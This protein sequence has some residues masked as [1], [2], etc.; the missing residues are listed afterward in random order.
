MSCLFAPVFLLSAQ[1]PTNQTETQNEENSKNLW[2]KLISNLLVNALLGLDTSTLQSKSKI[3]INNRPSSSS[4]PHHQNHQKPYSSDHHIRRYCCFTL[5]A[6]LLHCSN[7]KTLNRE[8]NKKLKKFDLPNLAE[9]DNTSP[10]ID[11]FFAIPEFASFTVYAQ[12]FEK[13]SL[14]KCLR[15]RFM[16]NPLANKECEDNCGIDLLHLSDMSPFWNWLNHTKTSKLGSPNNENN[17]FHKNANFNRSYRNQKKSFDPNTL[18]LIQSLVTA[19]SESFSSQLWCQIPWQVSEEF[20]KE[21][22]RFST[23]S[24][25]QLNKLSKALIKEMM[26]YHSELERD[27]SKVV[28]GIIDH[29]F[30]KTS[31][32]DDGQ[33]Q[34]EIPKSSSSVKNQGNTENQAKSQQ[35]HPT[36]QQM[37]KLTRCLQI[38]QSL[39]PGN[40]SSCTKDLTKLFT[41]LEA[42]ASSS[43]EKEMAFVVEILNTIDRLLVHIHHTEFSGQNGVSSSTSFQNFNPNFRSTI[44]NK[45]TQPSSTYVSSSIP[46][47]MSA[48]SLVTLKLDSNPN[49]Y[50]QQ[51]VKKSGLPKHR[52][53]RNSSQDFK[54]LNLKNSSQQINTVV[55]QNSTLNPASL[56]PSASSGRG[57]ILNGQFRSEIDLSHSTS[58]DQNLSF[59]T[60]RQNNRTPE[61]GVIPLSNSRPSSLKHNGRLDIYAK[62]VYIFAALA[63]SDFEHEYLY[64]LRLLRKSFKMISLKEEVNRKVLDKIYRVVHNQQKIRN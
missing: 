54:H 58:Y 36:D 52:H 29:Y 13:N 38:Y 60:P 51:N 53:K 46:T 32:S 1:K 6:L 25:T 24:S 3:N 45:T 35:K 4:N 23:K 34:T 14:M 18:S 55:S 44:G 20:K 22:M 41:K 27:I 7:P 17:S 30:G 48:Q 37:F 56:A 47:S 49:Q 8:S 10:M 61:P 16:T 19:G 64:A 11:S 21:K 59:S 2:K 15:S 5:S 31:N 57:T 9:D 42:T 28:F 12:L 39:T 40:S 43:Q 63:E 33:S 26:F 62:F 50:R